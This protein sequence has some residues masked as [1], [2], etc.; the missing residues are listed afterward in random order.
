MVMCA[1]DTDLKMG[2]SDSDV[3]KSGWKIA[4]KNVGESTLINQD[5]S[6]W[7]PGMELEEQCTV[8]VDLYANLHIHTCTNMRMYA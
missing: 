8:L 1:V 3:E 2:Q 4:V 5:K 7:Q 6:G